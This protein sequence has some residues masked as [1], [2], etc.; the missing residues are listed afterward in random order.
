MH[1]NSFSS[2]K[3]ERKKKF[4]GFYCCAIWVDHV[5][6]DA[7]SQL[8]GI[9]GMAGGR[10]LIVALKIFFFFGFKINQQRDFIF[11]KCYSSFP[12]VRNHL[13]LE[14]KPRSHRFSDSGELKRSLTFLSNRGTG[15][16]D[17]H[18]LSVLPI[19]KRILC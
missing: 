17:V 13:F 6:I 8:R 1:T 18:T 19:M 11:R 5:K 3:R 16:K 15:R 10:R 9:L 4:V 14:I 12:F 7:V 2:Q